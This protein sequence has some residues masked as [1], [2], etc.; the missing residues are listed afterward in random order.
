M[1]FFRLLS[2]IFLC[3]TCQGVNRRNVVTK[4][5]LFPSGT[6]G[7]TDALS[8]DKWFHNDFEAGQKDEYQITAKDVGELL[9]VTLKNDQ[10][11][12][13]SDWF[14]NRVTIKIKG[15]DTVYDF[16]CN[17]WVQSETIIFEGAGKKSE[18]AGRTDP[19]ENE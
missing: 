2:T 7:E 18:E 15:K 16:P 11:G 14:V 5:C 9:L 19:F 4:L 8:L 6:N 12:L 3:P 10:G 17:R 1:K 13:Y